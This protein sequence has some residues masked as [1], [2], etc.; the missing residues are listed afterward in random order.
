M[1]DKGQ[2]WFPYAEFSNSL[3]D[4]FK[5]WDAVSERR[6]SP[7]SCVLMFDRSTRVFLLLEICA[8]IERCGTKWIIG[9]LEDGEDAPI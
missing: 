1:R 8:K 9:C 4:A 2:E 3:D 7:L 6:I 5:L